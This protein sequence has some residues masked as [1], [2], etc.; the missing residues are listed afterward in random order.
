MGDTMMIENSEFEEREKGVLANILGITRKKTTLRHVNESPAK[1]AGPSSKPAAIAVVDKI[2]NPL[3]VKLLVIGIILFYL[4]TNF[5][6][7]EP[8][9]EVTAFLVAKLLVLLGVNAVN[10]G[11]LLLVEGIPGLEV[12]AECSGIILMMIFP[13]TIFLIPSVQL[14]HRLASLLFI[15]ILFFG[16]VLRITV[17]ALVGVYYSP[18]MILFFHDTV[19][20]VFIFFWAIV[21]YLVWLRL[22]NNFP[23]EKMPH[24]T[25]AVR[26]KVD[27]S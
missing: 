21:L 10:W 13:L 6:D 22:F 23:R 14:R 15:P 20:Q 17:D 12:S 11:H 25:N 7:F 16:N 1:S 27:A 24:V 4:V 19:G 5:P 26:R 2:F 9:P 8:F 18:D 3:W